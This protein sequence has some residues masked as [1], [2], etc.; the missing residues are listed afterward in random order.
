MRKEA[1]LIVRRR[2]QKACVSTLKSGGPGEGR[3]VVLTLIGASNVA[4]AYN[5]I[6]RLL[7]VRTN[8]DSARVDLLFDLSLAS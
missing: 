7:R 8:G 1:G 5:G 3:A 4:L 2:F 6:V